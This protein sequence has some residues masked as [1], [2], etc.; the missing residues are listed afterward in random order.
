MPDTVCVWLSFVDDS[1]F[2][3]SALVYPAKD[4]IDACLK[5][6]ELG[7]NPGGEVQGLQMYKRPPG[8]PVN[9]LLTKKQIRKLEKKHAN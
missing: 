3:G 2:L 4:T 8:W 5:A 7:I 6:H 9:V 1:G